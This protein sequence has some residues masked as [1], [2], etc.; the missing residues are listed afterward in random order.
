MADE[1]V[2]SSIDGLATE[3]HELREREA[4]QSL[5]EEELKRLQWLEVKLDQC[6]DLLR[7]RRARRNAGL[8]PDEAQLRDVDTVENYQQ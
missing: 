7:Q 2:H 4:R 3:E 1:D 5:N 6:W 8:D